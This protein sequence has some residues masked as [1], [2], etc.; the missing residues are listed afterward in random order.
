MTV[1]VGLVVALSAGAAKAPPLVID[2]DLDGSGGPTQ[3]G[4][5]GINSSKRFSNGTQL[6]GVADGLPAGVQAGYG[7]SATERNRAPSDN[8]MPGSAAGGDLGVL[9]GVDYV[10]LLRDYVSLDGSEASPHFIVKGLP[11]SP[12][13][14]SVIGGDPEWGAQHSPFDFGVNG[15][16]YSHTGYPS[17][18]GGG[19]A[20]AIDSIATLAD[21][22]ANHPTEWNITIT[23]DVTLAAGDDLSLY[24]GALETNDHARLSGIR[25]EQIAP[26]HPGDANIDE[27]VDVYDLA[28]LANNYSLPGDK[29]WEHADFNDDDTVDVY[30]LSILANNY[31][32]AAGGQAVPEPAALSLLIL[33]G[34]ALLRRKRP[35]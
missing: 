21:N 35:G 27:K 7:A 25:I 3:S 24:K 2:F 34:G 14:V 19:S 12:Y 32:W 30:D 11:A 13:K 10:S 8:N 1:I 15:A 4:W 23:V 6:D 29:D 9:D 22:S 33:T 20:A 28:I 26:P 16:E 18:N 5:V 31:G 17:L